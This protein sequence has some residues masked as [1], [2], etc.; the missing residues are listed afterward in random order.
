MVEDNSGNGSPVSSTPSKD[1]ILSKLIIKN[2]DLVTLNAPSIDLDYAVKG[3]I[4]FIR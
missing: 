4:L 3:M 1:R 2:S